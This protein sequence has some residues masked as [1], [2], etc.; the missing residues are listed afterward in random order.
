MVYK[1]GSALW[2]HPGRNRE[3]QIIEILKEARISELTQ[4]LHS[5]AIIY[6]LDFNPG[7]LD[8]FFSGLATNDV[9]RPNY[10]APRSLIIKYASFWI[11][12]LQ[13]KNSINSFTTKLSECWYFS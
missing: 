10:V 2:L 5:S 8:N 9:K 3:N 11:F 1:G 6:R 4:Q 7:V 12:T 13:F